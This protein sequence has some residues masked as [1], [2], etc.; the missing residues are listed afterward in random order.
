MKKIIIIVIILAVAGGTAYVVWG[1]NKNKVGNAISKIEAPEIDISFDSGIGDLDVETFNV[2]AEVSDTD[3]FKNVK[4][5]MDLG[6]R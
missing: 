1:W 5:D 4:E 3:F 2:G 6:V